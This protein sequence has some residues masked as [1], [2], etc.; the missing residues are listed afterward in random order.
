[1]NRWGFWWQKDVPSSLNR[2]NLEFE[3][4]T[5]EPQSQP[6]THAESWGAWLEKS[7]SKVVRSELLAYSNTTWAPF[8]PVVAGIATTSSFLVLR[9]MRRNP[10][11]PFSRY[12]S[13]AKKGSHAF[14]MSTG[15][16]GVCVGVVVGVFYLAGVNNPKELRENLLG[17]NESIKYSLKR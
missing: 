6:Q 17:F 12:M 11:I 4:P 7:T 2:E 16:N 5:P 13:A 8:V 15:V 10:E 14:G 9:N 1:M 3:K